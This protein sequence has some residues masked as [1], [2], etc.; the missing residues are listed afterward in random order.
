MPIEFLE[1]LLQC[2]SHTSRFA[3]SLVSSSFQ[4]SVMI[5]NRRAM[6]MIMGSEPSI[7]TNSMQGILWPNGQTVAHRV[8]GAIYQPPSG[9]PPQPFNQVSGTQRPMRRAQ[10][11]A[12]RL[13]Q[14]ELKRLG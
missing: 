13:V 8:S 7:D 14:E 5:A 12:L 4:S 11:K 9:L 3:L 1:S 10:A 6:M 2:R